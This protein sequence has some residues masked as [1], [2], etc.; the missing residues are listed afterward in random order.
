MKKFPFILLVGL[1]LVFFSC[2]KSDDVIDALNEDQITLNNTVK[3]VVASEEST[4]DIMESVDY[5]TDLFSFIAGEF[6]TPT[7]SAKTGIPL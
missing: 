1:A 5:E 4:E 6:T 2:D 3:T 7:T